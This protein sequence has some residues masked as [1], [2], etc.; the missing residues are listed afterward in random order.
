[1]RLP[2]SFAVDSDAALEGLIARCR[3]DAHCAQQYPRLAEDLA[4]LFARTTQPGAPVRVVD[5]L[6]GRSEAI[7]LTREAVSA[8]VRTPLYAPQLSALLPHAIV[9]ATQG[10]YDALFAALGAVAGSD[11]LRIAWGQHFAVICAEDMPRINAAD[12]AAAAATRFGASFIDLYAR[13]CAQV[14]HRPAPEAFYAT[15]IVDA[16]VLILSGGADPATPP[17]HGAALAK[18]LKNARHLVAPQIGHGVSGQ[19]C[20]PEL[21]ARF[22]RQASFDAIEGACLARLP[23]PTFYLPPGSLQ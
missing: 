17:R 20:A 10:D 15:P 18:Q 21:L 12:R 13:A 6:T 4:A 16:P 3:Q 2:A 14:P 23:A 11:P 8:V 7:A 22:I 1:M 9:R 5:P 19:G